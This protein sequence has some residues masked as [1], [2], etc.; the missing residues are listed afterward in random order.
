MLQ[1]SF[2]F[3]KQNR[4]ATR[5]LGFFHRVV[6]LRISGWY[7]W[8][9]RCFNL[10]ILRPTCPGVYVLPFNTL[11]KVGPRV[12]EDEV[13]AIELARSL[14][15]PVPRVLSYGDDGLGT[16]GPFG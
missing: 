2:H 1:P 6:L 12:R 8:I 3:A 13:H 9:H 15:V 4:L 10:P 5:V 11:L 16:D 14:G 7:R